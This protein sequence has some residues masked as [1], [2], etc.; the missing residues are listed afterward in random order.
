MRLAQENSPKGACYVRNDIRV[1][2]TGIGM[3]PEFQKSIFNS[4]T[5]EDTSRVRKTEGTGLG[6]AITKYII[7]EMG[8][9]IEIRSEVDRGTE[10]HIIL[11]LER[12][13]DQKRICSFP[14]GNC[15]W[16][17]MTNCFA[18]PPLQPSVKS[19]WMQTV[20]STGKTAVEMTIR[21]H[22]ERRDY[23]IVLLDWK[24]PGMDGIET[25][26]E[27]R[28]CVGKEIPILLIPHTIGARLRRKRAGGDQWLYL[29]APV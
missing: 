11:D 20:P 4:F 6:M 28:K 25:A 26:K 8:G 22:R 2:D 1:M 5:R 29:Q 3:S 18:G 13:A 16:L 14:T 21:R 27:I 24:M 19:E 10:F 23:Q 12:G 17:T 9:S 15:S 7:D